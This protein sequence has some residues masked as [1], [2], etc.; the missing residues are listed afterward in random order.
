[1][2]INSEYGTI[3]ESL[4]L[5]TLLRRNM[6]II[7]IYIHLYA[8]LLKFFR[9]DTEMFNANSFNGDIALRPLLPGR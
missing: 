7:A 9:N 5:I 3:E 4:Y 1:M 8:E 6:N 2:I